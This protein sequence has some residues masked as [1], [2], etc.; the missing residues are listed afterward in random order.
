M[1]FIVGCVVVIGKCMIELSND[2]QQTLYYCHYYDGKLSVVFTTN[3]G[4]LA[5]CEE[6]P[7]TK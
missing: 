2:W 3:Y 5:S 1:F 7:Q 4:S 6:I